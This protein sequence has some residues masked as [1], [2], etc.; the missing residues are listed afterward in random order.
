MNSKAILGA[1]IGMIFAL[2][3][4]M[5][6]AFASGHLTITDNDA[7]TTGNVSKV[8]ITTAANIPQDG[9]AGAF[10]Y[11]AIGTNAILVVTT[12]GG[13]G[14]DSEAQNGQ[15]DPVM[16]THVVTLTNIT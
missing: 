5:A 6:P 3:M 15:S 4:I 13:V 2:S 11:G 8:R 7:E 12:H 1:S 10:G 9:S 16:H 14:P